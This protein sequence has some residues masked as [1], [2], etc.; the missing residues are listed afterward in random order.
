MC[1]RS[2]ACRGG[3]GNGRRPHFLSTQDVFEKQMEK[4]GF[5]AKGNGNGSRERA[6]VL[7][8]RFHLASGCSAT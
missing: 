3:R 8:I 2:L 4:G 7:G 6:L 1:D 5:I